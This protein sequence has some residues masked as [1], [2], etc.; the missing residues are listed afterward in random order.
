MSR[1]TLFGS[2]FCIPKGYKLGK[3]FQLEACPIKMPKNKET[4]YD[5]LELNNDFNGRIPS[6]DEVKVWIEKK[7]SCRIIIDK[8]EKEKTLLT[9]YTDL[10]SRF[11][12][13]D[14]KIN[15]LIMES[16]KKIGLLEEIKKEC[17][18]TNG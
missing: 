15:T 2:K 18:T 16:N 3:N 10:H 17:G 13:Q 14:E 4:E 9:E 1:V 11:P 7:N 12:S 8:I 5:V 6:E